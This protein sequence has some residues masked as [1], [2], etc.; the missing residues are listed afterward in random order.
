[1]RYMLILLG[2]MFANVAN[3]LDCEKVPDCES[4][5]Y[6]KAEDPN[7]ADDGYMFCPFNHEY[8]KCVNMD[9]AKMGFTEDDKTSWC[10]DIVSCKG[11]EDLTLCNCLKPRCNI[12]DVLYAN[13]S[14]GSADSFDNTQTP[15][16]IV[17]FNDTC[18][19]GGKAVALK[20]L[21]Q[22]LWYGLYDYGRISALSYLNQED[23]KS[24]LDLESDI[25]NGQK[26]TDILVKITKQ[27]CTYQEG[28]DDYNKYC[29]ASAARE[30][31]AYIPT[32][33][34]E[35]N[36]QFG[37]GK[38]YLPAIGELMQIYGVNVAEKMLLSDTSG[39]TG[40]VKKLL[41]KVLQKLKGKGA[42]A[43]VFTENFYWSSSPARDLIQGWVIYMR[44]GDPDTGNNRSQYN[45]RAVVAF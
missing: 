39:M 6:S 14:C 4:L 21:K 32:G 34:S 44:N 42:D 3:A 35:S 10:K 41:N 43:E 22:P 23:V 8:K 19:G 1:M 20:D 16:G 25:Y 9:C 24:L 36:T 15:V 45:V 11:D 2:L 27:G 30:T 26:N 5:G 28:T 17:F 7:C 29:I 40:E 31:R 38:W 33:L 13:G 12:G 37:K 18:H